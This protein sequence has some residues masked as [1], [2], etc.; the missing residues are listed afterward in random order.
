MPRGQ[1]LH[2]CKAILAS[3]SGHTFHEREALAGPEAGYAYFDKEHYD[4]RK[5]TEG[6]LNEDDAAYVGLEVIRRNPNWLIL[7]APLQFEHTTRRS[8]NIDFIY[9]NLAERRAIGKQM[10]AAVTTEK[11]AAYFDRNRVVLVDGARDFGNERTMRTSFADTTPRRVNW[12]GL[13]CATA[14]SA[15]PNM[16]PTAGQSTAQHNLRILYA[17]KIQAKREAGHFSSLLNNA[18]EIVQ[19]RIAPHLGEGRPPKSE[20]PH[21]P[22]ARKKSKRRR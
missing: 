19:G 22:Q 7:P 21:P 3:E 2:D 12:G 13:I 6:M 5:T 20:R 1:V 16:S 14:M 18:V 9:L 17:K 10:K 11:Q 8:L 15:M 4:M